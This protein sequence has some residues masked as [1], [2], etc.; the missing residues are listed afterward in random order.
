M[1]IFMLE[2]KSLSLAINL[3]FLDP[4]YPS[5]ENLLTIIFYV[6]IDVLHIFGLLL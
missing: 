3:M 4:D 2:V 5:V 1:G 6:E